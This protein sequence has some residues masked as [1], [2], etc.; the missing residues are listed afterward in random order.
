MYDLL[1]LT[2]PLSLV[3]LS[4]L[5]VKTQIQF[6]GFEIFLPSDWHASSV[7]SLRENHGDIRHNYSCN[8]QCSK[9]AVWLWGLLKPRNVT[10]APLCSFWG[11]SLFESQRVVVVVKGAKMFFLLQLIVLCAITDKHYMPSL[12]ESLQTWK[13]SKALFHIPSIHCWVTHYF[14][15]QFSLTSSL[16]PPYCY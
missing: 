5:K 10:E 4:P 16:L 11:Q 14:K 9:W 7:R 15:Y 1:S 6:P 8:Y 3:F 2:F 13:H 12:R